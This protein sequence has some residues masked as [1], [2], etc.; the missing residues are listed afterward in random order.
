MINLHFEWEIIVFQAL[1]FLKIDLLIYFNIDYGISLHEWKH[2]I[3]WISHVVLRRVIDVLMEGIVFWLFT[4]FL[5]LF[6]HRSLR[7]DNFLNFDFYIILLLFHRPLSL[8][9]LL[10]PVHMASLLVFPDDS[11]G[12]AV[13]NAEVSRS[14]VD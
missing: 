10:S 3:M 8:P 2:H 1:F 13:F 9:F 6:F 5:F 4:L 7:R 14:P 12:G 11:L